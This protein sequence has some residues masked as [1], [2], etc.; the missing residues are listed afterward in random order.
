MI[1]QD[2]VGEVITVTRGVLCENSDTSY[3]DK[4][5]DKVAALKTTLMS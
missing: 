2:R 5:K 4:D 3:K 1:C